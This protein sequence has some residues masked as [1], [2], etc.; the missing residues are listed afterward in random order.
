MP[1]LLAAAAIAAGCAPSNETS[2]AIEEGLA[3]RAGHE[4]VRLQAGTKLITY[5][6]TDDDYVVYQDGPSLYATRLAPG[7]PRRLI[8]DVGDQQPLVMVRGR[9]AF[10]WTQQ[11]YFGAGGTSPLIV[12]TAAAGPKLA[13]DSSI[14]SFISTRAVTLSPD[15]RQI[16]FIA[17][18]DSTGTIGD[19]VVASPDLSVRQTLVAGVNVDFNGTCPPLAGFDRR[20]AYGRA[21]PVAAYCPAGA[22]TAT[23]SRWVSGVRTDL[24]TH[25]ATAPRWSSDEGGHQFVSLAAD[26]R[27]PIAI[28]ASGVTTV[29]EDTPALQ[30]FI[31]RD[32]TIV[33]TSKTPN[34][35]EIHRFTGQPPHQDVVA[36]IGSGVLFTGHFDEGFRQ[37]SD[38]SASPD[39][40][41][42][43]YSTGSDPNTGLGDM[44][45]VDL[46]TTPPRT[47]QLQPIGGSGVAFEIFTADSSHVLYYRSTR[48]RAAPRSSRG[49]RTA[50][51][52]RSAM[53][54]RPSSCTSG[55]AGRTW[56]TPI[57]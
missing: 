48:R 31:E 47:R 26:T 2:V 52:G 50:K 46:S 54:R 10:V 12:W 7:A 40:K 15:G 13:A 28:S 22:T 8:A 29:L 21:N 1:F 51:T 36:G 17:N 23:L 5:G 44:N 11:F 6:V 20:F 41:L 4:A 55:S 42:L 37:Y 18:V 30:A 19:L 9:V 25:L 35:N 27:A 38:T 39:G 24:S 3:D 57:T 43:M 33:A 34:G 45:V 49:P 16:I 14:G 53:E 56:C 32:G